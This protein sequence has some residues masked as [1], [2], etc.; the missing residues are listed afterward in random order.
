MFNVRI[1][2]QQCKGERTLPNKEE[3]I[4]T[5]K[6]ALVIFVL[7][8]RSTYELWNNVQRAVMLC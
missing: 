7:P 3:D 8:S 5:L 2:I 1:N 6:L 4:I